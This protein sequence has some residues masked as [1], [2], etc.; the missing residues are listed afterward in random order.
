VSDIKSYG[1]DNAVN[2]AQKEAPQRY[3]FKGALVV[4]D[5]KRAESKIE[6]ETDSDMRMEALI[7]TRNSKLIMRGV[8]VK[9]LDIG[10]VKP[11]GG[12]TLLRTIDLEM[13]RTAALLTPVA[14]LHTAQ[15]QP[16]TLTTQPTTA[17]AQA[18]RDE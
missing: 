18:S 12:V 11:M 5:F 13:S 9:N 15:D 1:A 6:L 17:R 16:A 10:E 3:D 2:Q 8:A 4:I 14:Q 7:D